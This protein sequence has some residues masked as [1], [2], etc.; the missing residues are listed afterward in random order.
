M[1]IYG[2]GKHTR[3]FIFVDDLIQA[4][5]L[6]AFATGIGGEV[7]QIA[8]NSETNIIELVERLTTIL[9]DARVKNFSVRQGQ[10]RVGDMRRNYS[11]TSKAAKL[12][13]W[14]CETDLY[15]GLAKTVNWFLK[16]TEI[17]TNS[18]SKKDQKII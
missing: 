16:E 8:S 14:K 15:T 10:Q 4:I 1:E 11:N 6:A 18:L 13:N 7:F 17:K 12:L 5:R 9:Y 3:D 2:D